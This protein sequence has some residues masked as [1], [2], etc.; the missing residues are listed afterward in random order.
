M[1][2]IKKMPALSNEDSQRLGLI[3]QRIKHEGRYKFIEGAT[4]INFTAA[5]TSV[6]LAHIYYEK[7]RVIGIGVR[8]TV[9]FTAGQNLDIQ[10]G[11]AADKDLFGVSWAF[12]T[13]PNLFKAGDVLI[14]DKMNMLGPSIFTDTIDG[15]TFVPGDPNGQVEWQYGYHEIEEYNHT[16]KTT[17]AGY[18]FILVE[19]DSSDSN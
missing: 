12:I 15:E 4:L 3:D 10:M 8:I 16:A 17:G 1:S 14:Q 2:L 5:T 6:H 13:A 7:W 9:N 18:P 11:Y 19:I